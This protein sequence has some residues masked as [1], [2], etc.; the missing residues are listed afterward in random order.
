MH[1]P[2]ARTLDY[3]W[4]K[5]AIKSEG[6]LSRKTG[7]TQATIHRIR[8]GESANPSTRSL[9]KLANFFKVNIEDFI[10]GNLPEVEQI[11]VKEANEHYKTNHLIS[12]INKKL[13]QCS[14][15]QLKQVLQ[16]VDLIET[17]PKP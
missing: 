17:P 14:E 7:L 16:F 2:A 1:T 12:Q 10:V 8:T 15:N 5:F 6:D 9:Q 13:N 4:K 11:T 3:L